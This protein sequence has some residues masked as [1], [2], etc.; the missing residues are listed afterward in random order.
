MKEKRKLRICRNVVLILFI[1][2]LLSMGT[3]YISFF[4]EIRTISSIKRIN[5]IR[6]YEMNYRGEYAFDKYLKT[7]SINYY[8][9]TDFMNANLLKGIPKMYYDNFECSTF[10][11]KTPEGDYILARNFDTEIAIP[12]ALKTNSKNGFR[13]IGMAN[14]QNLGWNNA[15]LVS[16]FTALAAPYYTFDGMNEKGVA[17]GALSVPVGSKSDIKANKVTLYD[18]SV[19]RLTIE[20]AKS[21]DDAIKQLLKYNVKMEDKYPSQYMIADSAGNCAVI[22]YVD[23]SMKV[24]EKEGNYQIATNMLLYNNENHQGYSSDRYK[25]FEKVLSE[26]DGIISVE[27]ALGLLIENTVP[28]EAQWSSVYNLTDKTMSVKFHGD[29]ENTY[30]YQL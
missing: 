17:I 11:A 16:K 29:Y 5:D 27:D 9:Y 7:G 23:G 2:I 19:I 26:T 3:I 24:V 10:F 18:Y 20:K 21:V 15:N 30:T 22:D 12:F 6:V 1:V 28:G 14:L 4:N 8:E 13:T 25:A